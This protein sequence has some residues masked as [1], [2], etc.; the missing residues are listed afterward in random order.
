MDAVEVEKMTKKAK[1]QQLKQ[2]YLNSNK[3]TVEII[4]LTIFTFL[5][6]LT[7][8]T[9]VIAKTVS[10]YS[11]GVSAFLFFVS[12]VV[13]DIFSG[14]IHWGFD[15]WG[16]INTP[17]FGR[18]IRSFREHHL[19]AYEMCNH[20]FIETNADSV[21]LAIPVLAYMYATEPS[22][23]FTYGVYCVFIWT[24]FVVCFTN[25]IHK[26]AHARQ[27]NPIVRFLQN[28]QMILPPQHHHVHHVAPHELYYCIANGWM[29]PFLD[30]INMWRFLEGVITGI[31]GI[32]PR[33]DD[34]SWCDIPQEKRK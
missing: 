15:S 24:A 30:K 9:H 3:R 31:T 23:P 27:V 21:I 26:W 25:E 6:P 4:T 12:L 5:W 29:N 2:L 1:Q 18:F 14:F 22:S 20:D 33:V 13:A 7:F 28:I 32:K 17:V 10:W 16:T 11:L 34:F 19:D 8:Y